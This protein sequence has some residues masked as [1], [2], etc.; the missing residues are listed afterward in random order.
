MS[1]IGVAQ[2]LAFWTP[3]GYYLEIGLP[4]P[5]PFG[6]NWTHINEV[7]GPKNS[8][9]TMSG[10]WNETAPNGGDSI[11]DSADMNEQYTPGDF[12]WILFAS[13]LVWLMIPGIGYVP[14]L[15]H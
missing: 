4:R 8:C 2:G 12:A 10:V 7:T 14:S 13:A 6:H 3:G 9:V 15:L 5:H 1:V 11:T